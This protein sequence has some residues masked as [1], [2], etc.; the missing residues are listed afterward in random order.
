MNN[1]ADSINLISSRLDAGTLKVWFRDDDV[2]NRSAKTEKFL[3]FLSSQEV[4]YSFAAIPY[5]VDKD[6]G[7]LFSQYKN[8]NVLVH[9]YKHENHADISLG[10]NEFPLDRF[11][12]N[13]FELMQ[14]LDLILRNFEISQVRKIFVPPWNNFNSKSCQSLEDFGYQAISCYRN[15]LPLQLSLVKRID[16]H[17][18]VIDWKAGRVK[19]L[20]EIYIEMKSLLL[21]GS[22]SIGFLTHHLVY[23]EEQIQ[24]LTEVFKLMRIC[25]I[26]NVF[27]FDEI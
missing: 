6:L 1:I 14:G 26:K 16:A 8:L 25:S 21:E 19:N 20:H 2:K 5:F 10:K 4:K 3:S 24:L 18:D 9:G 15:Y 22:Y 13:R 7:F 11:D 23:S 27:M 12:S 17:I